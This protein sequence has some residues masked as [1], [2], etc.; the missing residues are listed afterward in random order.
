MKGCNYSESITQRLCH[1]DV[2]P[3]IPEAGKATPKVALSLVL[4]ER[5]TERGRK[6]IREVGQAK[7]Q[8]RRQSSSLA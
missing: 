2:T 7:R 1:F 4:V 3:K 8:R 6:G 5:Q